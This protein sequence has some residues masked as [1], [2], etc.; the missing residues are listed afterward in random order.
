MM[1]IIIMMMMIYSHLWVYFNQLLFIVYQD[2]D[3][4]NKYFIVIMLHYQQ[5]F[6][7]QFNSRKI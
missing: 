7:V 6:I 1:M 2:Y 3:C 4:S 5:F